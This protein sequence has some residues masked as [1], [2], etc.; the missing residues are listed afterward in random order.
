MALAFIFSRMIS[1]MLL[2][3]VTIPHLTLGF[4]HKFLLKRAVATVQS[5]AK[6]RTQ[7]YKN[8]ITGHGAQN[9]W[10]IVAK[11]TR[12]IFGIATLFAFISA[13]PIMH[14][15]AR[16]DAALKD[17]LKAHRCPPLS[18]MG[19]A[20]K[21]EFTN[22]FYY[23]AVGDDQ[24]LRYTLDILLYK[25]WL[26][27]NIPNNL[28]FEVYSSLPTHDA[29][30]SLSPE[31]L[32]VLAALYYRTKKL[33]DQQYQKFCKKFNLQ[34]DLECKWE[35]KTP[36]PPS[37]NEQELLAAFKSYRE[38][39]V[40]TSLKDNFNKDF[41]EV[42]AAKNVT[43]WHVLGFKLVPNTQ[44]EVNAAYKRLARL[45]HTDK[46]PGGGDIITHINKAKENADTYFTRNL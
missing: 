20:I 24:K 2:G 33:E 13:Y 35:Y 36:A 31:F 32:H 16:E 34:E 6:S 21:K 40:D 29:R 7:S 11:D 3:A 27:E 43:W 17:I 45:Y 9:D 5:I 12:I 28:S 23:P 18:L 44:K 42:F 30:R 25:K 8:I 14:R 1:F 37:N 4:E 26:A 15:Q 39:I 10:D 19:K 22:H 41:E 38:T 46:N